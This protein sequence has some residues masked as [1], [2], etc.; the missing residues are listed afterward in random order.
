MK[1]GRSKGPANLTLDIPIL[2]K[3]DEA[4]EITARATWLNDFLKIFFG[5]DH[6]TAIKLR[7]YQELVKSS[8]LRETVRGLLDHALDEELQHKGL[9][10]GPQR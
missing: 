1:K 4:R 3:I 6:P 5:E 2:A 9:R 10:K 8:N 7:R